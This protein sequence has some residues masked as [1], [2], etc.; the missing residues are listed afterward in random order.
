LAHGLRPV[1]WIGS[2]GVTEGV[3]RATVD[4]LVEHE[5]VKVKLGHG[6]EGE[7]RQAAR[8]LAAAAEAD[9]T[10]V[11]GRVIVLYRPR[12][13]DDPRNRDEPPISLP[14]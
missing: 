3:V 10:Q 1:V 2:D 6:F 12:A 8:D 13:T 5:L 7:R 11:I 4:A 9:L 14:G